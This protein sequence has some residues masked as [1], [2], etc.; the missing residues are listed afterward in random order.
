MEPR[1][2]ERGKKQRAQPVTQRKN[3]FNGATSSRTW[4]AEREQDDF[5]IADVASMEPRPHERGKSFHCL[6]RHLSIDRLQ[7]SHVLTNVERYAMHLEFGTVKMAS[8]EPRP[9]ERGK[10]SR[11]PRVGRIPGSFNGA[12][13]SRTWKAIHPFVSL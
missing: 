1:P 13:S 10:R 12:T 8:M 3:C 5:G 4:K 7:W 2:H 6:R 9:H 11:S